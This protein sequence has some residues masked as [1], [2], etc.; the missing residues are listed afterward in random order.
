MPTYVRFITPAVDDLL[1]LEIQDPQLV[2]EVLKKCL[3][4]E[5]SALAGE[6]MLGVLIGLRNCVACSE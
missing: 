6:P 4:L 3:L 1:E 2:R 5:R